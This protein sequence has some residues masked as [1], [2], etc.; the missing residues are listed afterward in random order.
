[1]VR[2]VPDADTVTDSDYVVS[3]LNSIDTLSA[4]PRKRDGTAMSEAP[5]TPPRYEPAPHA[6]VLVV[7]LLQE[8]RVVDDVPGPAQVIEPVGLQR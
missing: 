8:S 1:M 4:H 6:M 2:T 3:A 7:S 5:S